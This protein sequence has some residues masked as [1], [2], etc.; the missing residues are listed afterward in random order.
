MTLNR[1]IYFAVAPLVVLPMLVAGWI[2]N[3]QI[4]MT[5]LERT[6]REL[7]TVLD[8]VVGRMETFVHTMEANVVLFAN[9]SVLRQYVLSDEFERYNLM[10]GP[11]LRQFASYQTAYPEYREIRII[12]TNGYEDARVA[13]GDIPNANEEEG[14]SP[15]FRDMTADPKDI[16]T[17]IYSNRDTSGLALIV[18]HRIRLTDPRTEPAT[19][20]PRVRGYVVVTLDMEFMLQWIR[21]ARIGK[22]GGSLSLNSRRTGCGRLRF[23]R[24][25]PVSA[26]RR[27]DGR[28]GIGGERAD[29]CVYVRR[30]ARALPGSP[31]VFRD[32]L[33]RACAQDRG[34]GSRAANSPYDFSVGW[35]HA[36]GRARASPHL[37]ADYG[38]QAA[39]ATATVDARD[40]KRPAGPG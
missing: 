24:T 31:C 8:Q 7:T 22:K 19:A 17:G 21:E 11:L 10:Q 28:V 23:G 36:V 30:T 40:R 12:Q 25:R 9:A 37:A 34:S 18:S 27:C 26:C 39:P 4:Q 3:R 16:H 20:V 35:L 5:A 32:D 33:T 6:T 1:K 38:A 15:F 29:P 13:V 2:A 14:E